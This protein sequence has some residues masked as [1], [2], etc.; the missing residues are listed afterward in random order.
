MATAETRTGLIGLSVA[1]LGQA[2]GTDR[3][4]EWVEAVDGGMSL[5]DLA[6]HIADSEGFQAT[7]PA[8]L[9]NGEFAGDFLG[10]VLGDNVSDALMTA[11]A[12]VV[13]GLLNDGMSRGELALAVVG[14]LHDIVGAGEDHPAY[15]DLGMAAMAFANQVAV[16]S[17]YTLDARMSDPS[18]DVLN[19]VTSDD[20]TVMAAIE[21]IDNPPAPPVE[22]ETGLRFVLTPT[23]DEFTGS[24]L[25]DIFVAQPVQGADGIFNSTLNSFDSIDGA[26]GVDTIHIYGVDHRDVLRLGAEDISNVENVII[27]TV[28]GIDADLGDWTGLEMVTLDRFGRE[29]EHDVEVTVDGATVVSDR[30]FNGDV[31]IVGAAGAVDIEASVSSTV[32]VGSAGHTGSVMVKG[33]ASITVDNGASSGNKQSMTVTSVSV[34]GVA[35]DM[36]ESTG[37]RSDERS[38]YN[39]RT[40]FD[41]FVL[42]PN[43][44]R[45]ELTVGTDG[46]IAIKVVKDDDS[47]EAVNVTNGAG[48]DI[49]DTTGFTL[50]YDPESGNLM[51]MR[52]AG[53]EDAA[54]V[55]DLPSSSLSMDRVAYFPELESGGGDPTLKVFSDAIES[56][57]L[58]N[59]TAIVLIDNNSK[60]ADGKRMP[61][62]LS[63][64]VNKYGTFNSNGTVDEDGK[65]CIGGNDAG[66]AEN[67]DITVAGASAFDLASA[68][69]KTLDISGDERLVLGVNNFREDTDPSNDGVSKTLESVTVSGAVSVA[70][71]KL[72]GMSKLKMI[73]ASASSGNNSF[74]SQAGSSAADSDQLAA[75]TMVMGGSGK[76]TVT[77]RTSV[78]GKLENIDTGDGS[79]T[80]TVTGL[81]R[82]DGLMVDLGAGDDVYSGRASNSESRI[83]GGDGT[84]VLHLTTTANSTYRDADNKVQSIYTGFE[85][86]NVAGGGGDYDIAQL[87][88]VNDVLVTASTAP[89][90]T[91]TL[92]NM[93]DGM[94]IRVSGTWRFLRSADNEATIVH[95]LAERQSGQSRASGELDLVLTAIGRNDTRGS[96]EGEAELTLTTGEDIEVINIT[97]SAS[98]HSRSST[99]ASQ[100]ARAS[101]YVNELTLTSSAVEEL[102]IDGNAK[103]TVT[104]GDFVS[105]ELADARDNSGGVTFNAADPDGGG[106]DNALSQDLEL[107]GGSGMDVLTGGGGKDEI[108]GGLGG[109]MLA[110]GEDE[111][112]FVIDSASESQA[113]FSIVNGVNTL[114][115]G[116]DTITDFSLDDD[117]IDLSRSL[118]NAVSGDIKN[119]TDAAT[120]EWNDWQSWDA[121]NNPATAAVAR[122]TSIDGDANVID[123]AAKNLAAFIGNGNGLFESR[124]PLPAGQQSDIGDNM[125]TNSY[126]IAVISQTRNDGT[127]DDAEELA[128][129]IWLL[130]DVDGDGDFDASNDMVIFLQGTSFTSTDWDAGGS[131]AGI[132]T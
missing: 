126:T 88:I 53:T 70:M 47:S 84:D 115:G 15:A 112:D 45:V 98:P 80:V 121:D 33:G 38:H 130:F 124:D 23:I 7:Y 83:D 120:G 29:D 65:L 110:G 71:D 128:Q 93:G 94:G 96:T 78:T 116:F 132:F 43:G 100:A 17:H 10:N 63:V 129:G 59:T 19:G 18:A 13:E 106:T 61:E 111:D 30:A 26:G 74:K 4:N 85:T 12:A 31:K 69:I 101:D 25:G 89:S 2:P 1:M 77:L 8:F 87:G 68:R 67:I 32:H 75:L 91:V 56:V 35:R 5:S 28:G 92:K 20:A 81:L 90:A 11:A 122:Y 44:D 117:H 9:T 72:S 97:S 86:L 14:A 105:L 107:V 131:G 109:D 39:L 108:M 60:M 36:P 6:N 66:S 125:T 58:H 82:N 51:W 48:E 16:A 73:D 76:D 27:S 79:D 113:R 123:G 55:P 102:I 54:A 34:D 50:Q 103:L 22:P 3:L 127:A 40:D 52:D 62:D 57:E 21:A 95:E 118:L 114:L 24:D 104:G 119:T 99:A 37:E 42:A 64:T 41:K 46:P 49:T